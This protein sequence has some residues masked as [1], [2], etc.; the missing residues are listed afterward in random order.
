M[1]RTLVSLA[2]ALPLVLAGCRGN[3][4]SS[5][6]PSIP[7]PVTLKPLVPGVHRET[8]DVPGRGSCRYTLSIPR[9][10]DGKSQVPLIV[11]LHYGGDV[12]PHYGKGMIDQLIQ[13]ALGE[14]GAIVLAP[15]A[16]KGDWTTAENEVAVVWLTRSLLKSYSIDPNKVLLTG[17][18]MGAQGTWY[19]GGRHQELFTALVVVAG[20]PT[21]GVMDWKIPIYVIHSA[22]DKVLPL[23]PTQRHVEALEQRGANVELKVVTGYDHY[24]TAQ[25]ATPMKSAAEW[26]RKVWDEK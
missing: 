17:F 15:D 22:D 9:N 18:S 5:A 14:L 8:I 19:I 23:G 21:G 11:A 3:S 7:D 2:F 6:I 20:S 16:S 26:L 25:F 10:Y 1:T 12:T 4:P 24:K 13:P